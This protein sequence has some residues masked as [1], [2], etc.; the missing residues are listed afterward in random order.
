VSASAGIA[1]F[2]AAS[3]ASS[4]RTVPSAIEYSLCSRRWTKAGSL[5]GHVALRNS[6]HA[7]ARCRRVL[8]QP[9]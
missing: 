4:M 8:H 9:A 2:A 7:A 6:R 3:I 1:S 5:M